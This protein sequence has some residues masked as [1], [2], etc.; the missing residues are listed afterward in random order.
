MCSGRTSQTVTALD[1]QVL[2]QKHDSE[3]RQVKKKVQLYS[4]SEQVRQNSKRRHIYGSNTGSE[5]QRTGRNQSDRND[6]WN[7]KHAHYTIW[8]KMN[9]YRLV[10]TA[11]LMEKWEK[12]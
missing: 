1:D 2:T 12:V 8:W 5:V 6:G 9:Q 3:N 11:R 10:Y 7:S 4:W